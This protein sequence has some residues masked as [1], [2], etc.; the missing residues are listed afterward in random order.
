MRQQ[1]KRQ[2]GLE[3]GDKKKLRLRIGMA[4]ERKSRDTEIKERR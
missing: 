1:K 4:T 2:K 3:S